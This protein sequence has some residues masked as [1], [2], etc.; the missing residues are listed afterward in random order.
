[1]ADFHPLMLTE[2]GHYVFKA[3]RITGMKN[4]DPRIQCFVFFDRDYVV[5]K[6]AT[7][8]LGLR[9]AQFNEIQRAIGDAWKFCKQVSSEE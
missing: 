9:N 6:F 3:A 4:S 7:Q 2:E 1:M 8:L 5:Q